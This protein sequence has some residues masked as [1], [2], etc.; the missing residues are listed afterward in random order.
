VAKLA[1]PGIIFSPIVHP[2]AVSP[3][4]CIFLREGRSPVVDAFLS[5]LAIGDAAAV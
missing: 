3:V 1:W 4:S 5:S 2:A